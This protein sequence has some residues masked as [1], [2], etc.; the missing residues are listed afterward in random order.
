MFVTRLLEYQL[1]G[2]AVRDG[3][4]ETAEPRLC[5]LDAADLWK[6]QGGGWRPAGIVT[7]CAYQFHGSVGYG[8]GNGEVHEATAVWATVREAALETVRAEAAALGADGVVGIEMQVEHR[9]VDWKW[10]GREPTG[11]LVGVS[12][13][14]TAIHR[15][16]APARRPAAPLRIMSLS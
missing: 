1:I 4:D 7:G 12:I 8:S 10:G 15:T 13:I 6:L 14:A 3:A 16:A 5:T 11:L 9:D 2:T